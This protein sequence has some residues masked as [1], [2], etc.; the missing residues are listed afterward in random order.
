MPDLSLVI[1]YVDDPTA[2]AA[3]YADLLGQPPAEQSP[4]FAMFPLPSGIGLGLW[5]RHTVEPT[6]AA[7]GAAPRSR[8]WP[9]TW[10]RSMPIGRQGDLPLRSRRRNW[11]SAVPS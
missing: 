10:M 6:A 3:F 2:S 7:A 5:S 9:R 11:I 8:S 4:T 1:L